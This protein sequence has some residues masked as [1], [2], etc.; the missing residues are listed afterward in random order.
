MSS[1][2]VARSGD[3]SFWSVDADDY[4]QSPTLTDPELAACRSLHNKA[5]FRD[6]D[7]TDRIWRPIVDALDALDSIDIPG[8]SCPAMRGSIHW[9]VLKY[10]G[11]TGRSIW[12]WSREDWIAV[13][14]RSNRNA[15][16]ETPRQRHFTI[17]VG[18]MYGL[19]RDFEAFPEH[20]NSRIVA[21][22]LFGEAAA[23]S[24][25]E[26]RD[27]YERVGHVV[28][29]DRRP[30][31]HAKP[32]VYRLMTELRHPDLSRVTPEIVTRLSARH[33]RFGKH[34]AGIIKALVRLGYLSAPVRTRP[35]RKTWA[36][37]D[38]RLVGEE[39]AAE[40]LRWHET[41]TLSRSSKND[42]GS[43]VMRAW[44]WL[45]REHPDVKTPADWTVETCASFVAAVDKL[46]TGDWDV[47][48][49]SFRRKDA[50][51]PLKPVT[52][53]AWIWKL[54]KYFVD[55]QAW[56]RVPRRFD[57]YVHLRA[58]TAITRLVG[59][60]PRHV[61]DA[62]WNKIVWA[63]A[64]LEVGDLPRGTRY[65]IEYYR[66]L[67]AVWT[68]TGRRSNEIIRL[69]VG[70]TRWQDEVITD[71]DGTEYPP[72]TTCLLDVPVS[73]TS[74]A[75]TIPVPGQVKSAVDA[76]EAVR[77]EQPKALDRKT[78]RMVD[79][80]FS[81][82]ARRVGRRTV[83][84]ALIALLCEKA[85][86]P[87]HDS[88]GKITSHRARHTLLTRLANGPKAMTPY[89][90]SSWATHKNL[91]S[92]LHYAQPTQLLASYARAGGGAHMISVLVDHDAV[93]SGAAAGGEPYTY[94]DLGAA[95]YCSHP[96]W[97]TCA[98]RMKCAGCFFNVPKESE[99]S[100]LLEQRENLGRYLQDVS[101]TE[102]EQ[103]AL[104]GDVEVNGKRLDKLNDTPA[105]DGR[106]PREISPGGPPP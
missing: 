33:D 60:Q 49:S 82:G 47:G 93:A 78:N 16:H 79:F 27:A 102:D 44:A 101:L 97:V 2:A 95:G 96:K 59:P 73:K 7:T 65:P 61:D 91:Q 20:F 98:H 48:I 83:N 55:L 63:A 29:P 87:T 75:K 100:Q 14:Q 24:E 45:A 70:C 11:E 39:W 103:E 71:R 99:R 26:F 104:A 43:H 94:Y 6:Y 64:N 106:T 3:A 84:G 81:Y 30:E 18:V 105:L 57:P 34:A 9:T 51:R 23:R 25:A 62:V 35:K 31:Y 8:A 89:E 37:R 76:W 12:G 50:G 32:Y 90:L 58:P 38:L 68:L 69:E 67:A 42:I 10:M 19:F 52:K 15:L 77:P 5:K 80:L 74:T 53:A 21:E 17:A 46:E 66:A 54:K 4:D 1:A 85:G 36:E 13:V 28:R 72:R 56:G 41:S 88:R 86:V 40:C 92:I 22:L